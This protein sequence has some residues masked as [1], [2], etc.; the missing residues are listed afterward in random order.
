M[1]YNIALLPK[2]SSSEFIDLAL[3]FANHADYLLGNNC[4][5]H[6]TVTMFLTADETLID[7]LWL[8]AK[9]ISNSLSISNIMLEFNKTNYKNENKYI[10]LELLPKF[11]QRILELHFKLASLL[12]EYEISCL[13]A[14]LNDYHPHLTLAR[15]EEK[16]LVSK[17]KSLNVNISDNFYMALGKSDTIGQFTNIIKF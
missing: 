4:L 6:L 9:S 14:S 3:L 11:D 12:Q 13:N 8:E 1:I 16:A 5:P 15:I 2:N 7:N 17:L 10:W